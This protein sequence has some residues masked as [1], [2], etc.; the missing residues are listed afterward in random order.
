MAKE[1]KG[2]QKRLQQ[3]ELVQ[4]KLE[5]SRAEEHARLVQLDLLATSQAEQLKQV[6]LDL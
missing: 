5:T 6:Q 1:A 4:E 2:L 3:A